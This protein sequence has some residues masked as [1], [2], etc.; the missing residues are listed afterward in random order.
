MTRPQSI[1][2]GESG[3]SVPKARR[4]APDG[5]GQDH[6]VSVMENRER[7]MGWPIALGIEAPLADARVLRPEGS[8]KWISGRPPLTGTRSSNGRRGPEKRRR[9]CPRDVESQFG[10]V[11][12]AIVRRFGL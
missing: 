5:G 2:L 9:R 3:G 6:S 10:I 1:H 4:E 8:G 7:G 12:L 11:R